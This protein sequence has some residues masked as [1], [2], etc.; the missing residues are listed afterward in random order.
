MAEIHPK[1]IKIQ[2]RY[3]TL[4]TAD[5]PGYDG[6]VDNHS[7]AVRK[8]LWIN[9]KLKGKALLSTIL[10][11]L[12][13]IIEPRWSEE[14]VLELENDL[15]EILWNLGYRSTDLGDED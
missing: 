10:H 6:L 12:L 2:G 4:T 15:A 11:E 9:K 13:H 5:I 7:K 1:R 14:A 8:H 3:W